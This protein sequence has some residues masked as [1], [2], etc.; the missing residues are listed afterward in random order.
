VELREKTTRPKEECVVVHIQFESGA[1]ETLQHQSY[2]YVNGSDE[3]KNPYEVHGVPSGLAMTLISID[4]LQ[5]AIHNMPL[6]LIIP[7]QLF[8]I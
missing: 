8:A 6:L 1:K 3:R 5:R 2:M 4:T 7:I